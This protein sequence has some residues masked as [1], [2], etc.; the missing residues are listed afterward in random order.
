M[1]AKI[2]DGRDLIGP[3]RDRPLLL[4]LDDG[5]RRMVLASAKRVA[6]VTAISPRALV[7]LVFVGRRSSG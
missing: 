1:S 6:M 5:A 4:P 2:I 3:R 7:D